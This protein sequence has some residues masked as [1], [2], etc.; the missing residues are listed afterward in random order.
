MDGR[1]I[2]YLRVSTERQGKS[3]LGI[4]AQRASVA[5]FLNGG[6]WE[7]LA[8]FV[9]V[10]SG[11]NND[12]PQL[13]EALKRCRLTGAILIVAKLDRLSRD[14]AFLMNL[15]KAGVEIRAADMP[16]ANT[17][18]FGIM[19][20][21]AQHEREAISRR[22]KDALQAA[23]NRGK[24]LGGYRGVPPDFNLATQARQNAADAFAERLAPTIEAMRADG[25]SLSEI[26]R[27][28]ASDGIM[29]ARGGQWTPT[30]VKNVLDRLR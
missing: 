26:A 23:K 3:G 21:V 9:E 7:L 15:S 18:M 20:L 2:S 28:L 6:N 10:E 5:I 11:R 24:V 16:E 30:A 19:A 22:T 17:M 27:K 1:Y 29:S 12:R 14:A 8:E 4:E 25:C 13:A